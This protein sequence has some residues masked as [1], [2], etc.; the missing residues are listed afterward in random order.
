MSRIFRGG[1][2][3]LPHWSTFCGTELMNDRWG[4]DHPGLTRWPEEFSTHMFGRL[5]NPRIPPI[6]NV[7]KPF[8]IDAW[9]YR[10]WFKLLF[11]D[12]PSS[13]NSRKTVHERYSVS[14]LS[15]KAKWLGISS[16]ISEAWAERNLLHSTSLS[17]ALDRPRLYLLKLISLRGISLNQDSRLKLFKQTSLWTRVY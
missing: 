4:R 12:S 13:I 8:E 16:L 5:V 15:W 10:W 7:S 17:L 3:V 6:V 9:P 14:L 11:W 2:S 1:I